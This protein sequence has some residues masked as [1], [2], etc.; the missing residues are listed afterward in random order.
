MVTQCK[1]HGNMVPTS[2]ILHASAHTYLVLAQEGS[3]TV[4]VGC[5]RCFHNGRQVILN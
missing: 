3:Q 1:L 2:R 4:P 5:Q